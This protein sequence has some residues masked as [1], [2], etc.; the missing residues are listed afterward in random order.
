M[1]RRQTVAV[2]IRLGLIVALFVTTYEIAKSC[3]TGYFWL[4]VWVAPSLLVLT[5]IWEG[6][7]GHSLARG[8]VYTL[9]LLGAAVLAFVLNFF[10]TIAGDSAGTCGGF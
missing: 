10:L 1:T 5:F 7:R 8:F 6:M 9:L 4:L 3:A 2:Y